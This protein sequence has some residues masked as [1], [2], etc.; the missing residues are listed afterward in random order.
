MKPTVF[1]IFCQLFRFCISSYLENIPRTSIE[2]YS[3]YSPTFVGV[4]S[5][6]ISPLSWISFSSTKIEIY[7]SNQ[8][9]NLSLLWS[10]WVEISMRFS[11]SDFC[12]WACLKSPRIIIHLPKKPNIELTFYNTDL[13]HE[14]HA[15]YMLDL[16][17]H[18]IV[19]HLVD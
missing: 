4:S 3:Q 19:D 15:L 18:N 17:T 7:L 2:A 6:I 10:D 12:S 13:L 9:I 11:F 5:S 8:I 1:F 16:Y 14:I